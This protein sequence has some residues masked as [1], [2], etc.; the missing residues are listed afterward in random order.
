MGEVIWKRVKTTF[1]KVDNIEIKVKLE[2]IYWSILV[3][4]FKFII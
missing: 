3:Y 1:E 2:K 4:V